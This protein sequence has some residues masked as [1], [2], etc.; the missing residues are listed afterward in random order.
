MAEIAFVVEETLGAAGCRFVVYSPVH[1]SGRPANREN[2]R[3]HVVDGDGLQDHGFGAGAP[4]RGYVGFD[5][6]L[7]LSGG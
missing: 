4:V 3:V 1:K 7:A 5:F 2:D 6:R